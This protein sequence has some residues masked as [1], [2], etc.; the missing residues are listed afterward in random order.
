MSGRKQLSNPS[1]IPT[2]NPNSVDSAGADCKDPTQHCPL[3]KAKKGHLVISVVND[4]GNPVENALVNVV[5]I[6]SKSTNPEG[7]VDFG[8]I[9]PKTYEVTAKPSSNSGN[10]ADDATDSK[11]VV[12]QADTKNQAT[13][14]LHRR[15]PTTVNLTITLRPN[16]DIQPTHYDVRGNL[17]R[18]YDQCLQHQRQHNW[19][20][21]TS[22]TSNLQVPR[23]RNGEVT[24]TVNVQLTMIMP[25]WADYNSHSSEDRLA[26]DGFYRRLLEHENGHAE[27]YRKFFND[28]LRPYIIRVYDVCDPCQ[29]TLARQ[30]S[31]YIS[32]TLE[33][34]D[35]E[36]HA[37]VGTGVDGPDGL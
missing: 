8:E 7:S 1:T 25:R 24:I 2:K 35:D 20:G 14:T 31:E 29:R 3:K 30:V 4:A 13:L 27:V 12:V 6:E 37:R 32:S 18:A 10:I 15:C 22:R 11:S 9:E 19:M 16:G 21:R 5:G 23:C 26:W 33:A 28:D 34:R 36:Y 17:R